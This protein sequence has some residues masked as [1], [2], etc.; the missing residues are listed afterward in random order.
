[1]DYKEFKYNALKNNTFNLKAV[2]KSLEESKMNAYQYLRQFQLDSTGYK[3][4]DFGMQDIY[5]TNKVNHNW[6]YVP[7]RWLFFINH[8]FINVGKRLAYKRSDLYEKDLSYDDIINHPDLF[9]SSFL[10][11]IDGKL[12]TEGVKVLC[13]EDK[14][15]M[16]FIC[17]EKPSE[18]GFT[19]KEMR[20]YIENNVNVSIFFIPNVGITN[21]NTN[22]YRVKT[23]NN[24]KGIPFRTLNLSELATYDDNT[25]T[26]IKYNDEIVSTPTTVSFGSSG[27][28][29]DQK[30]VQNTIDANPRNTSFSIQLIPLR[31]LF[32]KITITKDNKWFSLPIQDYPIAIENCLVFDINGN[33]IHNAKVHHYYPNVYSVENV[34]EIIENTDLFVYV[35]YYKNSQS[36]LKHL[37][38]IETYHRYVPNYLDKYKDNTIH[39]IIKD[40][41]PEIVDYS[42]NDFINH[43]SYDK[44]FRYKILKMNEFIKADVNNFRRYLVNLGLRNNYYYVDVTDIDLE[45]RKRNDNS[46]TG[47][48][49]MTFDEEMYMFVFRN[50]F[51]G[52]YDKLLV[53]VDGIRYESLHLFGTDKYDFLYIPCTLVKPNTV[54]EIEKLTEVLKEYEFIGSPD[55]TKIDIGEFAVRNKTLYNDLFLVD[56]ETS[57]YIDPKAYEIYYSFESELDDITEKNKIEYILSDS[58]YYSLEGLLENKVTLVHQENI[59][60]DSLAS[61]IRTNDE[62]SDD[63]YQLDI[64]IDDKSAKFSDYLGSGEIVKYVQSQDDPTIEYC[65]RIRGDKVTIDIISRNTPSN[66]SDIETEDS[67]EYDLNDIFLPCPRNIKIKIIDQ[68][69]LDRELVLHIKKNFR[70]AAT[71]IQEEPDK[72]DPIIFTA[73]AKNDRRYF[74]VYRNGRLVPRHL[75]GVKFSRNYHIGEMMVFPGTFRNKN[76]HIIV[77]MMPYMMNQVCYLETIPDDKVIDLTGMI[78]KPFDFKWHD[79]Y[80]NGRKLVKKEVEI[81]S[82]NRIKILKSDSLQWLEIVENS[83]DKEYFG[84]M[85]IKDIMDTIFENDKEFADLV[86]KTVKDLQDIEDPVVDPPVSIIDYILRMFYKD[87]M[88]PNYG[89][90]NPD[91]LQIDEETANYYCEIIDKNKPFILNGD[92][93]RVGKS[94]LQLPINPDIEDE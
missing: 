14:T 26:Y 47:L 66:I 63:I 65:F 11:F 19:I 72:L 45:A 48:P 36:V 84:Y 29:V 34:D 35:F 68:K 73:D 78:D 23:L 40:F 7:R 79:I 44:H 76:D 31:Y 21:I 25:L 85:P 20:D 6:S 37:D 61:E 50:D 69:Y 3:R 64:N 10:V 28:F 15:Y 12:Y 38:M 32:D 60:E 80:L 41:D 91:E 18:I 94:L 74:R 62:L 22:A 92:I 46:D 24:V 93:C 17:K 70:F 30:V 27:I 52:M 43:E 8:D 89:L 90:I 16:I 77:E 87:Y 83:R 81:L 33:F 67:L 9:E 5:R 75:G 86:N 49:L 82:A 57:E 51:R 88:V 42:I 1:M 59:K 39:P 54:I 58:K 2:E 71:E 4:F 53:H 13:K 56:K 55:Y